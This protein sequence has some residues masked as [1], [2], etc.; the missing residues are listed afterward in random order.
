M[1]DGMGNQSEFFEQAVKLTPPP[2][3]TKTPSGENGKVGTN[4]KKRILLLLITGLGLLLIIFLAMA[5]KPSAPVVVPALPT[6][7]V[8]PTKKPLL[9]DQELNQLNEVVEKADPNK[10]IIDAPPV[11]MKVTF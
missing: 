4:F 6:P 3:A 5:T 9:L 2:E 10:P 8:M 7:T 1:T 11:D